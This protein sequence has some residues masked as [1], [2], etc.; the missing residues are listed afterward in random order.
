MTEQEAQERLTEAKV[1][2]D[3]TW[4][5]SEDRR[6][7]TLLGWIDDLLAPLIADGNPDAVFWRETILLED[8]P[9][10]S[11]E[12]ATARYLGHLTKLADKG[13]TEAM[14]R[15]SLRLYDKGEFIAAAKYCR[16]AADGGHAYANW[17]FGLDL[18]SGKGVARDEALGLSHI[19]I[20]A[21][22][23]FEGALKFMADAYTLG[24]YGFPVDTAEAAS[25]HRKLSDPRV[26]PL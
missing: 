5:V 4:H 18:L 6:R 23:Y 24:Q 21:E 3:A 22:L 19:R 26:I 2:I 9:A 10:E 15:L 13:H 20:A 25:W 14:F 17:C 8:N 1:L 11:E 16:R 7:A 12:D